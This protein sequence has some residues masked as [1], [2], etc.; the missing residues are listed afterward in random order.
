M[1]VEENAKALAAMPGLFVWSLS[2][3]TGRTGAIFII[4]AIHQMQ[5]IDIAI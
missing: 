3:G 1:T 2:G 4:V 5:C